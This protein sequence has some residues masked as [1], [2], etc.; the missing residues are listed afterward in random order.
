MEISRQN[1]DRR[2]IQASGWK[3]EWKET[4]GVRWEFPR[5]FQSDLGLVKWKD[6]WLEN[7]DGSQLGY[8]P[9]VFVG[10]LEWNLAW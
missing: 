9:Q 1:P 7:T 4:Q 2:S 10:N 5:K 3:M 8:V 6:A